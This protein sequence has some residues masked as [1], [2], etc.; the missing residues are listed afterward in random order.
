MNAIDGEAEAK[1]ERGFPHYREL[2]D[3][4]PH[5]AKAAD[6]ATRCFQGKREYLVQWPR[7][8]AHHFVRLMGG[9]NPKSGPVSAK[10]ADAILEHL[11]KPKTILREFLVES[12]LFLIEAMVGSEKTLDLTLSHYESRSQKELNDHNPHAIVFTAWWSGMILKRVSPAAAKKFRARMEKLI[13]AGPLNSVTERFAIIT[14][15]QKGLEASGH[16]ITPFNLHY[17][18]DPEFMAKHALYKNSVVLDPYVAWLGG[19]P[20]LEAYLQLAKKCDKE[21][22]PSAI[23]GLAMLASPTAVRVLEVLATKKPLTARVEAALKGRPST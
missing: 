17:C 13:D 1:F 21:W 8:V 3:G 6:W 16:K 20:M 2:I 18:S 4:H 23:E 19:E 9:A 22:A 14:R 10:E 7:E 12:A 5:D 15:G 11:T